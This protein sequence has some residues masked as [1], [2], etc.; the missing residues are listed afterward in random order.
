MNIILSVYAKD[1]FRE[2]QLPS[3]NNADYTLTLRSDFFHLKH[4]RNIYLEVMDHVW[5]FKHNRGYGI[6]KNGA[7]YE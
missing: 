7:A 1:A 2:F 6:R 5:S 4:N 3:V